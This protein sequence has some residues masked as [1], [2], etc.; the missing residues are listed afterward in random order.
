M[1][2]SARQILGRVYRST[3]PERFRRHLRDRLLGKPP[4]YA[5]SYYEELD[6]LQ[7]ASYGI[8][9]QSFVAHFQTTGVIDVGC[10]TGGLLSALKNEG[11]E[12]LL[13]LD[14]LPDA[15]A[16]SRS[17]G[18]DVIEADL[19]QPQTLP[20]G[21][22]LVTCLEVAEHLPETAA[23]TLVG[24]LTSGPSRLVFSAATPGQGGEGH[25]NLQPREYWIEKFRRQS[26]HENPSETKSLKRQWENG[27]VNKWYYLNV[28]ALMRMENP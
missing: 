17:R 2:P 25:I 9:A 28:I 7:A 23:D 12:H 27:G 14:G 5:A 15:V 21:F 26:W 19:C 22:D 3:L 16:S 24:T 6:R 1:R 4:L 20:S 8:L 10:G 11:V 13:G 18:L